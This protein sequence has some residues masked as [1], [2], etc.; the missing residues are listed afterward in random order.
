[1]ERRLIL[2]C[3]LTALLF[4]NATA[5]LCADFQK[6][7]DAAKRGDYTT[8]L[9]ELRPLA[10]QGHSRARMVLGLMYEKGDGVPQD[11]KKAFKWFRLAAEKGNAKAHAM[12]GLMYETGRGVI[13][14]IV[15]AYMWFNIAASSGDKEAAEECDALAN[16][17][18][19]SQLERAKKLSRECVRKKYRGC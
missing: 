2:L 19:S 12:M 5:G 9:R 17:M 7:W 6:G 13:Q 18:T 16:R 14:D 4:G 3:C 15:Q 8:A 1:M 11:Y 10:E